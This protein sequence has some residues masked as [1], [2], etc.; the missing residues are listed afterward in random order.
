MTIKELIDEK[1]NAVHKSN[2]QPS[3]ATELL[4][5]LSA[6]MGNVLSEI[7]QRDYDYNLV[8][9]RCRKEEKSAVD[10]KIAAETSPEYLAKREAEDTQRVVKEMIAALKYFIRE[11]EN[12][13]RQSG[14]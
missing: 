3:E 2:L 9:Q 13:Y 1:R 7:R 12:E 5:E 4:K 14:N 10:A 8:L 6:L 11:A